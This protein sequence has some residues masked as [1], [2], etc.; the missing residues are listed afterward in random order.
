MIDF[1][2]KTESQL[3]NQLAQ[4]IIIFAG[5]ENKLFDLAQKID[6]NLNGYISKAITYGGFEGKKKQSVNLIPDSNQKYQYISV[7][8]IGKGEDTDENV[9]REIGAKIYEICCSSNL[10]EISIISENI[11]G[12]EYSPEDFAAYLSAG[13]LL[14]S[15]KFDKYK[16]IKSDDDESDDNDKESYPEKVN[17][18]TSNPEQ[19]QKLFE[20]EQNIASGVFF[21]RDL[22]SE[23]GNIIYPE[24]FAERCKEL[25]TDG[26][27]VEIFGE[28]ELAKLN[29]N[30]LLAVGQGSDKESHM[31]VMHYNGNPDSDEVISFIGKGVTFDTGGISIKPSA[32]MDEMKWDMGG[33]GVVA[34]LIKALAARKAKVNVIGAVGLAENMPSGS[35]IKPGDIVKSMSGQ[36][37]EILN[38]DAEGRLVLSDVLHYIQDKYNP[39]FMIDLATLTGAMIVCLA[40]EMAGVFSND[41][42]LAEQLVAAGA[43]TDEQLWRLPLGKGYDKMID[44]PIADM[45]NIGDGRG[46]G[47]ITA[48]QFLQRFV[49]DTK[50]AHIDIAGVTWSKKGGGTT[51]KGATAF[52]VRLLDRMVE[53]YY[54]K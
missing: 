14:R 53:K 23:P 26:V 10:K 37:V 22:I 6:S 4:N 25:A 2:F 35:A 50:W 13:M 24:S 12:S 27:N 7:V 42:E 32:N 40:D 41:D 47:S 43:E 15:Y 3:D 54:E 31:V 1:S 34:G 52:G 33:A 46:A 18:I 45:K 48:A 5:S 38:T 28:S 20:K 19:S 8:G 49:G 9:I 51:P 16:T 30:C 36:T 11:P 17:I 21:A 39:A 44:S 29:A